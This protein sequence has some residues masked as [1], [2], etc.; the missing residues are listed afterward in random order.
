MATLL[1][2]PLHIFASIFLIVFVANL[3]RFNISLRRIVVW[4]T[5]GLSLLLITLSY[6]ASLKYY[7]E[8][9]SL[10]FVGFC[11][12]PMLMVVLGISAFYRLS[13]PSTDLTVSKWAVPAIV[14]G[15][16][17]M[18]SPAIGY[19]APGAACNTIHRAQL[20]PVR[21]ALLAYQEDSARFPLGI[22]ALQPFYLQEKPKLLCFGTDTHYHLISCDRAV[23]LEMDDFYGEDHH[24]LFL[25]SGKW[26]TASDEPRTC[27]PMG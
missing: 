23:M 3:P 16:L 11:L 22:Q 10:M 27:E 24:R 9:Q 26:E 5:L 14:L 25:I 18:G 15:Y 7:N 12:T 2:F 19:F 13:T 20:E 1:V 4:G 17:L 6:I 21:E 8:N